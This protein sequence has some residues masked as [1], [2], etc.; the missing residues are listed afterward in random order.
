MR[1]KSSD[2]INKPTFKKANLTSHALHCFPVLSSMIHEI[3]H[4][5]EFHGRMRERKECIINWAFHLMR[6]DDT[7]GQKVARKNIVEG[8]AFIINQFG[9]TMMTALFP[10]PPFLMSTGQ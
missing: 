2:F 4:D 3:D 5:H 10:F 7:I 8:A 6:S 9:I 1:R